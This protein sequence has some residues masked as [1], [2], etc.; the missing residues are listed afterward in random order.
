M[1]EQED[2]ANEQ[3]AEAADTVQP[4]PEEG[5][6]PAW[7]GPGAEEKADPLGRFKDL[8]TD[9]RRQQMEQEG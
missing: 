4:D 2:S 7:L 8:P 5:G 3:K 9:D 1:T 6:R